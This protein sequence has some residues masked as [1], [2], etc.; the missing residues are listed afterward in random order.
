MAAMRVRVN[1]EQSHYAVEDL[2]TYFIV[3]GMCKL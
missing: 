1:S 3:N 2:K